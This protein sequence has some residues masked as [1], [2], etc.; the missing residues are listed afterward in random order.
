[1]IKDEH[2]AA[3]VD[4]SSLSEV[5]AAHVVITPGHTDD[6]ASDDDEEME[7]SEQSMSDDENAMKT[8]G[9]HHGPRR[10]LR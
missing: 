3:Q 1:M 7:Q 9:R 8:N 6:E 5:Q 10:G 2:T 4:Q